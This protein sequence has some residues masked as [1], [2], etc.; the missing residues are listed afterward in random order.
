MAPAALEPADA[1]TAAA[2]LADCAAGGRPL[3]VRGGGTK[4][5]WTTAAPPPE[6]VLSTK[7]LSHPIQHFAGDLVATLP[8]GV[9]LAEANA[10]LAR[11]RQWLPLDPPHAGRATIG[12]IVAAN[13]SG[14]R[15]QQ[16]GAPRDLIIGVEV[17]LAD[18]RV[19]RAGGRVVKN[20]AGYDLSRLLCGSFGA[21]GVI[22]S[23]TFKLV[24]LP[25]AST[26]LVVA[27][28]D[29]AHAQELAAAIAAAPLTPTALEIAL[30]PPR[31]LVRF[32]TTAQ[33]AA[34]QSSIARQIAERGGAAAER[35]E[36][37]P[38]AQAWRDHDARV[39]DGGGTIVKISVLP[40]EVAATV[41]ELSAASSSG[42]VAAAA[43]G[44]I[45]LGVL[46][47]RL[48]GEPAEQAAVIAA[49][50]R[51]A[52]ASGQGSVVVLDA[53]AALRALVPAWEIDPGV[54]SV[55]RAVKQRFDPH[56]ILAGFAAAGF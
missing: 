45:A 35:L 39:W 34:R 53:P 25:A 47:A 2:L 40:T 8:A 48:E 36:G 27:P 16:Y 31:L 38:E 7:L 6:T 4:L 42:R 33:A 23:A 44:R 29:V 21:L 17:A 15:R 10:A 37:G 3:V 56:G 1:A 51:R 41:G 54:F 18:G 12:G 32:E 30:F 5:A 14:P 9:T 46:Y 43:V 28:R 22:T 24:P 52:A 20:V 13:D 26:T 55:M 49:L 19:A 50:R 11:E